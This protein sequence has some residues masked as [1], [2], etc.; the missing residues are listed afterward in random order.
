MP[1][2]SSQR[3]GIE[4]PQFISGSAYRRAQQA[5]RNRGSNGA[6]VFVSNGIPGDY[7]FAPQ[8]SATPFDLD[9]TELRQKKD[10]YMR[11]LSIDDVE[12]MNGWL[13]DDDIDTGRRYVVNDNAKAERIILL[14]YNF[15]DDSCSLEDFKKH[16][17]IVQR[18]V[19][20]FDNTVIENG[21]MNVKITDLYSTGGTPKYEL[22]GKDTEGLTW[23][24]D[25]TQNGKMVLYDVTNKP[26]SVTLYCEIDFMETGAPLRIEETETITYN[27]EPTRILQCINV[28]IHNLRQRIVRQVE[29]VIE[30]TRFRTRRVNV[31]SKKHRSAKRGIYVTHDIPFSCEIECYGKSESVVGKVSHELGKEIGFTH[32]GSLTSGIGYPVELQT[33][34]LL[35]KRGEICVANICKTLSDA[36]F[37]I[38]K[39]CGLHIHLDGSKF[40]LRSDD[41]LSG[42]KRPSE[43]I[44]MY[45]FYRLFDDVIISFLPSTRRN[46]RY[47]ASM[48]SISEYHDIAVAPYPLD[49]SFKAV[50]KFK[51]I[52][53]F[54]IYWYKLK[55]YDHVLREKQNRYTPTRYYGANFHSLLK[56]N[57]FEIRYHSGTL[58]SEKILCWVNLHGNIMARCL[59][60]TINEAW[61]DKIRKKSMDI[62]EKTDIL[63]AIL[64]LNQDDIDYFNGRQQSF[65]G[66]APTDEI[67]IIK[68][69]KKES[70]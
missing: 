4:L 26:T 60:G 49:V 6:S 64:G 3:N 63:Y 16:I 7:A 17:R 56:D 68:G 9:N 23:V 43:L 47:C 66:Q 48:A 45:L 53:E 69:D 39:T 67:M 1:T 44:S 5:L 18:V 62:K 27:E 40:G 28:T 21:N 51:N 22:I 65:E 61:L 58:I 30:Q 70:Y 46:N 8:Y 54:E 34:I 57:H 29:R 13:R 33:P 36:G 32:D 14:D 55:S 24:I 11:G 25:P 35:G 59:D 50:Q 19:R 42:M 31:G 37:K 12:K 15:L 38:D 2:T 10:E 52:H 20:S 41:V